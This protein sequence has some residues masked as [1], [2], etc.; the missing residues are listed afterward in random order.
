MPLS[1]LKLAALVLFCACVVSAC[2]AWSED[3]QGNLQSVGLPGVPIWKSSKPPAPLTPTDL[4]MTPEEAAKVGG[5]V[6]VEPPNP[7]SSFYR[8][9]FYSA[10]HN[11][12]E[13]D[14]QKMLA[15]RAQS[16]A[17]GP[18][19]YCT[20]HPTAPATQGNAFAF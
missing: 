18:A 3:S 12:C 6:L 8:Y 7:P 17:T 5:P 14:L 16:G 10:A 9:R 13:S 2:I 1:S 15:K 11:N 19:P 20:E 4:G